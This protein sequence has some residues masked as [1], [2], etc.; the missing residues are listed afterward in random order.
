MGAGGVCRWHRLGCFHRLPGQDGAVAWKLRAILLAFARSLRRGPFLGRVLRGRLL[1]FNSGL[2]PVVSVACVLLCGTV[3]K[4]RAARAW[5]PRS[6]TS[7]DCLMRCR[8]YGA[9]F[10]GQKE[11]LK[12]ALARPLVGPLFSD[13]QG[14]CAAATSSSSLP[15]LAAPKGDT[16]KISPTLHVW[17]TDLP[18]L[19]AFE[20]V[21]NGGRGGCGFLA[22]AHPVVVD[23]SKIVVLRTFPGVW[24][25]PQAIL[26]GR[27]GHS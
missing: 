16:P 27:R 10:G 26:F 23:G 22:V 5:P 17:Y 20:P 4:M 14:P 3:V 2:M 24:H 12:P 1:A 8:S 19:S 7:F 15:A 18:L 25:C 13:G 9:G 11:R 6:G 21:E